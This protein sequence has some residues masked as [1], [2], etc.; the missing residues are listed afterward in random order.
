LR[1]YER[2][3]NEEQKRVVFHEAG[4]ML[5]I[6]G[7]GSGKTRVVTYRVAR[8][9]EIGVSPGSILLLT[10]TNKAAREMLRRVQE[11]V[12]V[13]TGSIWGG[14]F[15]HV[16]NLILRRHAEL[17]GLKDAFS[18]LDNE[19]ARDLIHLLLKEEGLTTKR[20]PK[21]EVLRELFSYF[22][23]TVKAD[24]GEAVLEKARHLLEFQEEIERLYRLYTERKRRLNVVDFD[25]LLLLWK[26][27]LEENEHLR[28]GYGL[29]FSQILVDEYQD[30]NKIQADIV[31]LMGGVGRNV[32][33]VGDDA[34]SIYSFRGARFENIMEFPK[35]YPDATIFRLSKNYRS[36][37]EI[38]SFANASIS[39]NRRQFRKELLSQREGGDLPT[40]VCLTDTQREARFV[41]ETLEGLKERGTPLSRMAVLYRAHYQCIDLQMELT[42]RLIPFEVRSGLRFFEQAHIKDVLSFLKVMLNPSDEL[43]LK[44]CLKIFPGVGR[45]TADSLVEILRA[46][47]DP[48]S[49]LRG[50]I[51]GR[52]KKVSKEALGLMAKVFSELFQSMKRDSPSS[53]IHSVVR[54]LYRDYLLLNFPNPHSRLEDLEEL[55]NFA[56]QYK[57]LE[58]FLSDLSLMG[59]LDEDV[60]LGDRRERLVL[61]TIHQAKG[62]EWDVVFLI[63]CNEGRFPNP[64]AID[65]GNLEEERRLFYVATTRAKNLLFLSYVTYGFDRLEGTVPLFPSRF[66][67]EVPEGTYRYLDMASL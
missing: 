35:R 41:V 34:Q 61:S 55:A 37:K 24:I 46:G 42:R 12:G 40:I 2:E 9:L 43:S 32:M 66:L 21:A 17:V 11:L 30:T 27:L 54:S 25:D 53:M 48:I 49:L 67:K 19:D 1:D 58:E 52:A 47:A 10:F 31:D 6:A 29:R 64:R 20:F 56:A 3:L 18:I 38:L 22:V 50:G 51:A 26:R 36:T 7:A 44:R 8:L 33:V 28:I 14:T 63:G 13:E 65:D 60:V 62:L 15:H 23:N 57:N 39:H 4:P 16:G 5:V 45:R 59:G